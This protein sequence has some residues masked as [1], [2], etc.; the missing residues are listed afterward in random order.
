[1]MQDEKVVHIDRGIQK[2]YALYSFFERYTNSG[3]FNGL[4]T[5]GLA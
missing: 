4:K 3:I 2:S 1:M 5:L